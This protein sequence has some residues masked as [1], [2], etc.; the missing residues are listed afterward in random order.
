MKPADIIVIVNEAYPDGLIDRVWNSRRNQHIDS[1]A[2]F[3]VGEIA[4]NC[5]EAMSESVQLD[6][7]IAALRRAQ[8]RVSAVLGA[9]ERAEA[10]RLFSARLEVEAEAP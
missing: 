8:E 6:A 9:L 7:A 5:D 3:I 10:D 4:S 1:L 2:E